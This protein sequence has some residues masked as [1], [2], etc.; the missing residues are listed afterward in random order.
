[1]DNQFEPLA[2]G[3]VLSVNESALFLIGHRTFRVGEI[4]EAIRMQLEYGISGWSQDKDGWFSEAGI[5][6]E[7]LRF[8]SNGWQKGKVRINLE[9]CPIDSA[10]QSQ[11]TSASSGTVA[12]ASPSASVA[13]ALDF[14]DDEDE[15][16]P[17][18]STAFDEAIPLG[19][20]SVVVDEFALDEPAT[21]ALDDEFDLGSPADDTGLEDEFDLGSP[22]DDT[23]LEDEFELSSLADNAIEPELDA[24]SVVYVE[25]EQEV[26]ITTSDNDLVMDQASTSLD[27]DFDLGEISESI[28]Q[29]LELVE[30][31]AT[32][33]DELIDLGQMSAE[34]DDDLD[35]GG[36][37]AGGEDD[38]DFGGMSAGGEDDLDFGDLSASGE[39]EFQF[40]EMSL[41]KELEENDTDSLLDDVWQDMN[42]V[43]WQNNQ[44]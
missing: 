33:D 1:V 38:L 13:D 19:A 37:S 17:L 43:N 6:C 14:I 26:F 4:S 39:D 32:S 41:N 8:S 3:E 25:V 40:G 28:E 42:E 24:P 34:S 2:T 36:M 7:V 18:D 44:I 31:P 11:E 15:D 9:F 30:A 5:P 27:D 29:E 35:F 12:T 21:D 22:A 23:A 20:G 10:D 16:L